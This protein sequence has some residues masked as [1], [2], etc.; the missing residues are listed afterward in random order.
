MGGIELAKRLA[1]DLPGL[2]VVLASG[3]SHVL[4]QEGTEGMELLRKPY[5]A[6]QLAA[7]FQRRIAWI[8][9]RWE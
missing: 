6:T 9:Q 8:A 5:S 1:R 4:V 7:A 2:P 3:Y